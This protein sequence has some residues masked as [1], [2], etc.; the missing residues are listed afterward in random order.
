MANIK[1]RGKV[2]QARVF[3]T[4]QTGHRKSKSKSGFATKKEAQM[5]ANELQTQAYNGQL[6]TNPDQPLAAYFQNWYQTYKEPVVNERTKA[7]YIQV[8]HVLQ[9]FFGNEAIGDITRTRYQ[10]FLTEYGKHRSKATVSKNNSLIHAA[11]KNA[12]FDG[13]IHKD[14]VAQTSVIFDKERTR[15]IEYLNVAELNKLTAYLKNT[16]NPHFTSKFMLLTAIYTGMRPGEIQGLQWKNISHRFKTIT[17][18]HSWSEQAKD[19]APTKNATSIRTIR[20][21]QP[22][23]DILDRLPPHDSSDDKVFVNQYGTISTTKAINDVLTAALDKCAIHFYSLRHAH[24]AY[25]LANDIPLYAISKR[26]GH[27][28]MTITARVY[29][30][31]IEEYRAKTDKKIENILDRLG[32]DSKN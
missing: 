4:D 30:Y 10:R 21:G 14:F 12:I 32:H 26:L 3:Y 31:L 23:L 7:S 29:A 5:Y 6:S 20:I 16:L 22:L 27:A 19:F 17:I 25:L 24:V 9:Q 11:V 28:D 1:K 13:V 18:N 15:R 8:L 2:W